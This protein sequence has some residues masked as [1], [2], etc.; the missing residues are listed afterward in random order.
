MLKGTSK[1]LA[2]LVFSVPD[3]IF[4][5]EG[6]GFINALQ[7]IFRNPFLQASYPLGF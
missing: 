5:A 1:N 6:R 2:L 3:F 7:V 4:L